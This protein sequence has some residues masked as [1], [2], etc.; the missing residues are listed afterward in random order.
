MKHLVIVC[1]L[2]L[3]LAQLSHAADLFP[4]SP[5]AKLTPG[6]LCDHPSSRRYPEG[7]AYCSRDVDRNTKKQVMQ[8]YDDQL[9][10]SVT[11]MNR[12]AFKI[13]HYIPLCMGGSNHPDNLWPQHESIYKYTDLIEDVACQKMAA[14]RLKQADAIELVKRAKS[15]PS[16][17]AAPVLS[18][19]RSL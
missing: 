11:R 15:D 2:A 5:D 17:L 7:I 3:C 1:T 9:G 12:G 10:F 4:T 8:A 16:H 13:D 14:G 18:Q 19:I 6:S